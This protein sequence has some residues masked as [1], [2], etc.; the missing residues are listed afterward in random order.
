MPSPQGSEVLPWRSRVHLLLS[1]LLSN[2]AQWLTSM[3]HKGSVMVCFSLLNVH[4]KILKVEIK[5]H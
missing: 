2:V 4:L 3:F 1:E 5:Q